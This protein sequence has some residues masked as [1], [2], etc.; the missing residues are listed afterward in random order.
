MP[1]IEFLG[2]EADFVNGLPSPT[3]AAKAIP[4][5]YKKMNSSFF[6][7]EQDPK[8]IGTI[9]LSGGS[10]LNGM[11]LKACP[12]IRDYLCSGYIVPLWND[13]LIEN[14]HDGATGF[15]WR[16]G[17]LSNIEIHPWD[18][19]QSSIF[20][21][22]LKKTNQEMWKLISPWDFKTPAGYS[23]LFFSPE[24]H[25]SPIKIL[26]AIVDTDK[27]SHVNFPFTYEGEG[28]ELVEQGTPVVQV[29]PFKREEWNHEIKEIGEREHRLARRVKS[30]FSGMYKKLWHEKKVFR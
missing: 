5:W 17:S 22:D 18:Q 10:F 25:K 6:T 14:A 23:C 19:I 7:K 9:F 16:D 20:E 2:R 27:Y 29:L 8:N 24:Y 26:P 1:T 12:P 13:L 4:D 28:V 3:P 15:A 21:A 30:V 11:T